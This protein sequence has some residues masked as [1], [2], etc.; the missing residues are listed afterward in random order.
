MGKG[1]RSLP[2]TNLVGLFR[3]CILRGQENERVGREESKLIISR[4]INWLC[5]PFR[6]SGSRRHDKDKYL[7][8]VIIEGMGVREGAPGCLV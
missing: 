7:H 2:L 1:G 4:P 8:V 5:L 3:G 6:E